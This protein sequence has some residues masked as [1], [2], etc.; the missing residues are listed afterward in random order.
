MEKKIWAREDD[1]INQLEDILKNLGIKDQAVLQDFI[2]YALAGNEHKKREHNEQLGDLRKEHGTLQTR[3]DALID[4]VA[5]GTLTR[6]EFLRKKRELKDRQYE[7]TEMMKVLDQV[8]D[9][10]S[11]KVVDLINIAS[12]AYDTYKGSTLDEKRELLKFVFANLQLKGRKLEYS[13]RYPFSEFENLNNCTEWRRDRDSNPG[14]SCPLAGFQDQCFQPL[15]H[16][17]DLG[18][19]PS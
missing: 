11:K 16:L 18:F 9:E 4:L 17:S 12:F 19:I 2:D 14:R 8:D 1:V 3:L 6:D 13:L 7:V 15:S 10:F 5:D